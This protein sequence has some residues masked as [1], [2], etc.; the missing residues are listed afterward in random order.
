M[1][2][3][4]RLIAIC[5]LIALVSGLFLTGC[6]EKEIK[7]HP[8]IQRGQQYNVEHVGQVP[9]GLKKAVE[10]NRFKDIT[11]FDGVLLKTL[12]LAA[13]KE[14]RVV[15]LEVQ[16]M[17]IYGKELAAY[18][19]STDDAYRVTTL[20]ATDDGGFLFALGFEDYAYDQSTWAS[21]KGFASRII[22]C[23]KDGKLQFDTALDSVEGAALRFCFEKDGKFYFFGTMQA[24]E[25]KIQGTY[26]STDIYMAILDKNGAL[27]KSKC[28]AGSDFDSLQAIE[29]ADNSFI[30]SVSSQS[31]DG[32]FAG[33]NS[34]GYPKD[35]VITVDD[36]LGIT[37]KKRESGRD[38]FDSRI[39]EK[40]GIPVY[41][42]DEMLKNFDA[43]T[44]NAY[45]DYGTFYLIVSENITGAYEHTPPT[46]DSVWW[47]T[48]TVYSGYDQNGD[49]IFRTAVDSSPDY[50][51]L[52][53][54]FWA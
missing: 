27:L 16:M 8:T 20:T 48:E 25:T 40:E 52:V 51:I 5:L 49:L 6:A 29:E 14:K 33:S 26:S 41:K 7:A 22:K 37:E 9:G 42:T 19:V 11:A 36:S 3:K 38:Y 50:D 32:D 1:N 23:D 46:L 21:D 18:T 39:G 24:S 54:D 45:I 47:Y 15:T 13:D 2:M 44:P 31:D 53:R 17:D 35:W 34:G 28:I 10:N 30:L 43:G 4:K 12:L